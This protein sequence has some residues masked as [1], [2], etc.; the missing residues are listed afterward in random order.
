MASNKKSSSS[1][2][3]PSQGGGRTANSEPR[4][5][6][7]KDFAGCNFQQSQR[8]FEQSN[9]EE[10]DQSNL[11]MNY[12]VIQNN[13]QITDDKCIETRPE[14]VE[15]FSAPDG[16]EFTDVA[17]LIDDD[18]HIACSDKSIRWG[19][20]GKGLEGSVEINDVDEQEKDNTWTYLGYADDKL[21]G[22]TTG[23][24]LWTGTAH[25]HVIANA[26][27]VPD[28]EAIQFSELKVGGTL[29]ISQTMTQDCA[30]RIGLRRTWI[31]KYGPTLASDELWFYA[32]KPTTEWSGACYLTISGTAPSGYG[33][34]AT[35]LYYTEGE[36]QEFAFLARVDMA[37]RDG[38]AWA[39]N[40]TGYL[41]D[42]SMWTISNL[43]VPTKNYTDGVPA[44]KMDQHD[45]RLYFYGGDPEYRLW[46]GGNPGNV[47]SISTGTGGGY[48][49][50]EPGTGMAIRTVPKYKTQSGNNIVTIL[51]DSKNSTRESRHNL[52]E[53]N[54]TLSNEQSTKG[55]QTEKVS[56]A[57]GCK[58]YYGAQV[59]EDGLYAV[60]RYGLALTTLTMEYNSQIRVS[61][62]S[63][64]VK[65][66][67]TSKLGE[68][69]KNAVLLYLDGNLY[70]AFGKSERGDVDNLVFVY[71]IK[72]K[73]W[74]TYT[75]DID[76]PIL[77][78]MPIDYEGHQEGIGIITPS[79]VFLLPTTRLGKPKAPKHNVLIETAELSTTMPQQSWQHLTQLDFRF[80]YFVGELLIE[81]TA[82]DQFG[83]K[84]VTKKTVKEEEVAY[85]LSVPMRIDMKVLAYKLRFFGKADFKLTHYMAKC[86]TLSNKIGLVY[87]FDDSQTYRAMG[88]I[89]PTF[90][91]YNDVR[92][93]VFV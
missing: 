6:T 78:M 3:Q 67:F 8:A 53:N 31:N 26:K 59:C 60:S 63:D 52:V 66:A 74:W 86:Y 92:D 9:V 77:R 33:I 16:T 10:E 64:A 72:L 23:K 22:M 61:H 68:H 81:M 13:A 17:C 41:F 25:E 48:A 93:A 7:F 58:S 45:G 1:K 71:D 89:H 11:Q 44:S 19:T 54:I 79:K 51:C 65:P 21:V 49:D 75:L 85:G 20:V 43:S 29:Q 2:K 30:F 84:I 14:L 76:E 40:W 32:N 28:P 69:L 4:I 83:R 47:F 37:S 36:Y 70:L 39:Y 35:E 5:Q 57:V 91:D 42:T 56:G 50:V 15:L 62:V 80:D 34:K 90:E 87:G 73:S 27:H 46:I 24:Q 55:W 18:F 38:G 82:I 88:D 12:V